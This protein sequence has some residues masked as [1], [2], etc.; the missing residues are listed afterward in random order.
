MVDTLLA[1]ASRQ[2]RNNEEWQTGYRAYIRRPANPALSDAARAVLQ[3]LYDQQGYGILTGQHEY[4]EAPYSYTNDIK[5]LT[6]QYPA[7]KGVEFGGITGQTPEQLAAYRWGVVAAC[8]E[9]HAGGGMITATYHAAYPGAQLTWEMV[10]RATSQAEFNQIVT[11][12]T[13]L[14]NNLMADLD[15]VAQYLLQ[16]R[17]DGIPV[18]WRPY[19]EMN[20][21][22][23]WWGQKNNFAAL[24][25]IIFDRFTNYHKLDNLLWVW[26]PNANNPATDA[27]TFYPGHNRVDVLGK[28]IYGGDYK[29]DHYTELLQIGQGKLM[30]ITECDVLP[31]MDCLRTRQPVWSWFMAWGK[32][33]AE[34]NTQAAIKAVYAVPYS[35]TRG[36]QAKLAASL[37]A[38]VDNF[39]GDGLTGRYYVGKDFGKLSL[40]KVVSQVDFNWQKSTPVGSWDMSAVWSGY[41]RPN[42]SGEHTLIIRTSGG[43]RLYMDGDPVIDNWLGGPAA[44]FSVKVKLEA[45]RYHAIKLEYFNTSNPA[46]VQFAWAQPGQEREVIPKMCLYSS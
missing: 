34:K 26:S 13:A 14:Y 40:S 16:L 4:L 1:A 39:T 25:E 43:A 15:N 20:G 2:L 6:G 24:W 19:H 17:D 37:A 30:A 5:K 42:E 7:V 44:E 3:R 18:L 35:I 31:D 27:A 45:G 32:L 33:L 46:A 12:G 11:P 28:D 41:L 8:R 23:F 21:G 36:Q 29:A 22:W 10:Q 9:W 38:E